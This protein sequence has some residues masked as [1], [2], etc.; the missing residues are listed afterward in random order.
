M[1]L[2]HNFYI[3]ATSLFLSLIMVPAIRKWAIDSGAID[4]PGE[5]RAH[6][7]AIARAGG[8]AIFVPFMFSVLVYFDLTRE[9]RGVLAGALLI[10]FTGLI[11]DLYQLKAKQKFVGE[12]AGCS[13]AVLVGHLY[14]TDLG[15]LFGPGPIVLPV[16]S[17]GLLSVFALVGVINALN[18]IDGLDGLAGGLSVVALLAFLWLGL[19]G[20]NMAVLALVTGLLGALLGFLKFNAFPARIFMGDTGSLV[21]GFL[22]GCVAIMLTQGGSGSIN[23]VVPLMILSVPIVDTLV[24]M[25]QRVLKGTSMLSADRTHLHHKVMQLGLDH[26]LT[27]LLIHGMALVWALAALVFRDAPEYVLFYAIIAGSLLLHVLINYVAR[28]A[29]LS[30]RH[31][32]IQINDTE[33]LRSLMSTVDNSASLLIVGLLLVSCLLAVGVSSDMEQYAV[34]FLGILSGIA[35]LLLYLLRERANLFC[36]LSM[37]PLALLNYQVESWS[38]LPAGSSVLPPGLPNLLFVFLAVLVAVKFVLVKSLESVLD[39]SFEFI[40]FAMALTLAVVSA[41]IDQTYHLSGVVSKGII[42][43]LALKFLARA[44]KIKAVSVTAVIILCLGAVVLRS[45]IV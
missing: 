21:V 34:Y 42:A 29:P 10:F 17:G 20:N 11:D 41:D 12:I 15:N 4:F 9:V 38:G 25:V 6:N 28:H 40:L 32:R 35:G 36:L 37:F 39:F 43:F 26:S 7:R 23:A 1:Q 30:D 14:L 5:R 33:R 31:G 22:L 44:E 18:F 16:W 2:M 3:F 24:V 19:Q 8:V 13:V 45:M 27:V